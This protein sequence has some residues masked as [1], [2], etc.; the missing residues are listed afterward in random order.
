MKT[1]KPK[2]VK[3]TR[4]ISEDTTPDSNVPAFDQMYY[5]FEI[6]KNKFVDILCVTDYIHGNQC[7]ETVVIEHDKSVYSVVDGKYRMY[8]EETL[9]SDLETTLKSM[10]IN[11]YNSEFQVLNHC[12]S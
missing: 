1:F 9:S 5:T 4:N 10:T 3:K 12:N 8:S 2:I 7:A 6:E 11:A